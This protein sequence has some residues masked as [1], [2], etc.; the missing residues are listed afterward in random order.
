MTVIK[1]LIRQPTQEE[2]EDEKYWKWDI[3]GKCSFMSTYWH[4]TRHKDDVTIQ[5][6][7][8]VGQALLLISLGLSKEEIEEILRNNLN[9]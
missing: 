3:D 1:Y 6:E 4:P 9:E 2:L 8:Q 7:S 5:H